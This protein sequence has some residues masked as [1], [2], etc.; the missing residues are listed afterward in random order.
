MKLM[1][2]GVTVSAAM[3]RS[4]SF[5]RSLSSIKI[6]IRPR[7]I[8][9]IASSIVFKG[10]ATLLYHPDESGQPKR[11]QQSHSCSGSV[12]RKFVGDPYGRPKKE[13]KH[14]GLHD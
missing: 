13:G 6:T 4:P 2:S 8:S 1:A 10:M 3:Q 14:R 9:S 7:R 11:T 12:L 5:S